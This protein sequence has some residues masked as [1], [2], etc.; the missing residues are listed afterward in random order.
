M[1]GCFLR[2]EAPSEA[3]GVAC[4]VRNGNAK[5]TWP[6]IRPSHQSA[7]GR[8]GAL[9]T[10][11]RLAWSMSR[12]I[13]AIDGVTLALSRAAIGTIWSVVS[14]SAG[15]RNLRGTIAFKRTVR[16][17]LCQHVNDG[18]LTI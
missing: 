4:G 11:D 16:Y 14:D 18:I 12:A 13:V 5:R 6:P 15:T 8:K 10:G 9:L 3:N 1:Q 7:A 2:L 17:S